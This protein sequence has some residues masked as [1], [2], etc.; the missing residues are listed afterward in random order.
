[1]VSGERG[2]R[3][4]AD[5]LGLAGTAADL[6]EEEIDAERSV[7]V[8]EMRLEL[9][10][11]VAKHVGGV[12]DATKDTHAAGVGDSRGQLGAS[13]DVHAGKQDG[14]VDLEKIG[15]RGPDLLWDAE[16]SANVWRMPLS[17]GM[18]SRGQRDGGRR[19]RRSHGVGL[20]E[21]DGIK[22]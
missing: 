6:G 8:R 10:D 19:T 4:K 7:L 22:K 5:I 20:S 9:V 16:K 1:M 15:D 18:T 3:R 14:V 12:V 11:L 17:H 2:A 13:S 21:K